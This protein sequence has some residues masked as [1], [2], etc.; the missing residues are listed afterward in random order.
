M[1]V[2]S[3]KVSSGYYTD[4]SFLVSFGLVG[5][6]KTVTVRVMAELIYWGYLSPPIMLQL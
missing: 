1:S 6:S 3:E 4:V 5:P 2:A